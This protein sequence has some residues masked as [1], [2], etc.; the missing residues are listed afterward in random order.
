MRDFEVAMSATNKNIQGQIKGNMSAE[1][2][3]LRM[4]QETLTVEIR[5]EP[6]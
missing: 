3:Q 4:G 5:T 1:G 6:T 2:P